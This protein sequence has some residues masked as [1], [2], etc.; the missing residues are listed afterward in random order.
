M[1]LVIHSF[2]IYWCQV[3]RQ[4]SKLG[5]GAEEQLWVIYS[6]TLVGDTGNK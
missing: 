6:F 4:C 5:R 1:C 3:L 2:S